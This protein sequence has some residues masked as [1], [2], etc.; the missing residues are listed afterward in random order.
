MAVHSAALIVNPHASRVTPDLTLAVE[1]E[2]AASG[3]VETLLTERPAHAAELAAE[4]SQKCERIF[5]Y[6]GDGTYNEVVNGL[7]RD[8]PLGFVPGGSTSVLP[9]ALGLP[10]DPIESARRLAHG[11]K[12]KRISLGR[13][14]GRRFT[15]SAGVGLDAELVRRV[16]ALGRESGRRASDIAFARTLLGIFAER[17]GR[18]ESAMEV[19]GV[20]RV[21]FA[22]VAN[23]DPYSYVGRFPL[24][25]APRARFELGLDLVAPRSLR[26]RVLPQVAWWVLAGR[27]QERS[28]HLLYVHDADELRI[29]CDAPL[30]LQVDG[31][32]LGDV[33]EAHFEAERDALQV[34]TPG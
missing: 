7:E 29:V 32:D 27:G 1:R 19:V 10:R 30:P 5:V 34:L 8:I 9:R 24:R 4:V 17:R 22:L 2:L 15:F 6:S 21:A 18:F 28:R 13:V 23:G 16:D 20:G 11:A 3:A 26:A 33:D 14:N 12:S 31:E 25:V